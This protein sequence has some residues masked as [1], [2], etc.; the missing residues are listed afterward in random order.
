MTL[1]DY[2]VDYY[3]YHK[4]TSCI[5]LELIIRVGQLMKKDKNCFQK[6]VIVNQG[7]QG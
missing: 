6:N 2:T 3:F 5:T 1:F 7:F 4:S